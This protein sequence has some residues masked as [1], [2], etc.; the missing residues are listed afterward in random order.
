[1]P[2]QVLQLRRR[3]RAC[4]RQAPGRPP[5]LLPPVAAAAAAPEAQHVGQPRQWRG[6]RGGGRVVDNGGGGRLLG[7]WGDG[8]PRTSCSRSVVGRGHDLE[9]A[10]RRRP[11]PEGEGQ[12]AGGG[13]GQEAP[14]E[15]IQV[16]HVTAR[17]DVGGSCAWTRILV[18]GC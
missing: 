2:V 7:I 13:E 18:G 6:V 12:E 10:P 17:R 3:P 8:V 11:G 16:A 1:V 15:E 9:L 14:D 5:V 4:D